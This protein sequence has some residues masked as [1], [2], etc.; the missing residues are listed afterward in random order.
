METINELSDQCVQ[1][2]SV[3]NATSKSLL[4]SIIAPRYMLFANA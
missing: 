3:L 1:V 4:F 2:M